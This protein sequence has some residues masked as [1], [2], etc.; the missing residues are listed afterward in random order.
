MATLPSTAKGTL[1]GAGGGDPGLPG[2]PSVVTRAEQEGQS[3]RKRHYNSSRGHTGTPCRWRKGPL[4]GECGA[5]RSW[6]GEERILPRASR[7]S[8]PCPHTDS[9]PVRPR[10]GFWPPGRT[11]SAR[12][13]LSHY[14]CGSPLQQRRETNTAASRCEVHF[15]DFMA[16]EGSFHF[17]GQ[18]GL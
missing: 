15:P 13:A 16:A 8:P 11:S 7:R 17:H 5:S 3:Q 12:A 18:W 9:S 4:G 6:K 10:W 2:G 1:G 14:V